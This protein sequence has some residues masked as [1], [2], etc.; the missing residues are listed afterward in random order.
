VL[1]SFELLSHAR[2]PTGCFYPKQWRSYLIPPFDDD[3]WY[4]NISFWT[5][6]GDLFEE[7]PEENRDPNLIK[8][9]LNSPPEVLPPWHH[10][11]PE[12]IAENKGWSLSLKYITWMNYGRFEGLLLKH[13]E[14]SA[15]SFNSAVEMLDSWE[16]FPDELLIPNTFYLETEMLGG[17]DL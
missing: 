5:E 12:A 4:E 3:D 6:I 8:T 2:I 1:L 17:F 15:Q 7:V 9:L 14:P 11:K 10:Q 16:G 13:N